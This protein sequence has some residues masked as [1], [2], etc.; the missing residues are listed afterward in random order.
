[1]LDAVTAMANDPAVNFDWS[2]A[3]VISNLIG[4]EIT[5]ELKQYI[6]KGQP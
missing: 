6:T 3:A 2:D 5:K 1:M 4:R